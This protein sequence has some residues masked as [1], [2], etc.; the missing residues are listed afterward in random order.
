MFCILNY[1]FIMYVSLN[2]CVCAPMWLDTD[3]ETDKDLPPDYKFHQDT[4]KL[5]LSL[6]SLCNT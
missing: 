4:I 5:Q 2:V 1:I 3:T 6:N